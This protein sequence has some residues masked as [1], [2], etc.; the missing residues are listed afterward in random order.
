MA[1]MRICFVLSSL[2]TGG[3][4]RVATTLANAWV[5][6]GHDV[7]LVTL[8]SADGDVYARDARIDRRALGLTR[9]SKG[10]IGGVVAN[11]QR[12][13]RLRRE[14]TTFGPDAIVSFIDSTNVLTLLAAVGLGVP[15]VVSERIDPRKYPI[16]IAWALLRRLTYRWA[17]AL[18]VQTESV[19]V[20][21]RGV[22]DDSRIA[23]I[24]NPIADD[25][26][27]AERPDVRA[28][29]VV[30]MGRLVPQ[31]GFD[32][33]IAAFE[34][35]ADRHPEWHLVIAGQGPL[36]GSLR[37]QAERTRCADRISFAG[38]VTKPETLLASSEIFVLSSR[39]EGF[40]NVLLEGMACGCAAIATDCPSGPAEIVT[41]GVDGMLVPTDDVGAMAR[42]LGALM[43]DPAS[44]AR[45][46][47]A[48]MVSVERFRVDRVAEHWTRLL[49][50]LPGRRVAAARR[51][52]EPRIVPER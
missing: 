50:S 49:R 34:R 30:A 16:G 24:P 47:A 11:L 15:V 32:T 38:L 35:A 7:V 23:I 8:D 9:P 44:R 27:R 51:A 41:S 6:A 39:F 2:R 28:T 25:C 40:P 33:L 46:G 19:A 14:L 18:V 10:P 17:A 21:A 43:S 20:W 42:S 22:V 31:K 26:W 37:E 52:G 48:A 4:E 45:L 5:R 36:A 13:G 12:L 1:R 29:R 3:A